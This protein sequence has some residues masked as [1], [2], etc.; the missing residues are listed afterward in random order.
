M[1]RSNSQVW[2]LVIAWLGL[3]ALAGCGG[4]GSSS[5]PPPAVKVG[6][7]NSACAA[8]MTRPCPIG[9]GANWQLSASVSGA[10]NQNVTW[11]ISPSGAS[12]GTIASGTGLYIAPNAVPSPATVTITATSV[13]DSSAKASIPVTVEAN[14]PIGSVSSFT[15]FPGP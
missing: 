12:S 2:S 15:Q 1:Q 4:G 7:L 10:A 14:D 9:L 13:A 3:V 11:S 8:S 5:T 6:I